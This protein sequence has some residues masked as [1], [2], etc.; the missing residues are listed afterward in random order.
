[1]M[2]IGEVAAALD[3]SVD[4]LRY[5]EKIKLIPRVRRT[6]AGVRLYS[7]KDLSRLRFIRRAQTTGF[8]LEEIAQLLRF[9]ENPQQAKSQ[10]RGLAHHKLEQI[11]QHLA[12][13]MTLR[14]ELRLLLNL[15]SDDPDSCPI[16]D[17]F[18]E[19]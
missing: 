9:R 19:R 4:T 2:R 11:E 8:S 16:L 3:I 10:V 7:E 18:D 14:D 15:C 5:Y 17:R 12:E 6:G 1:M 13:L